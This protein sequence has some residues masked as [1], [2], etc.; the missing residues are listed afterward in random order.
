L[1]I[2]NAIGTGDARF[3]NIDLEGENG[4]IHFASDVFSDFLRLKSKNQ[5]VTFSD[6]NWY[7]GHVVLSDDVDGD[8]IFENYFG[9]VGNIGHLNQ[10]ANLVKFVSTGSHGQQRYLT[11]DIYSKKV[12]FDQARY[13]AE[14]PVRIKSSDMTFTN[15]IFDLNGGGVTLDGDNGDIVIAKS[16]TINY[17]VG[18][19]SGFEFCNVKTINGKDNASIVVNVFDDQNNMLGHSRILNLAG[20]KINNTEVLVKNSNWIYDPI[21]QAVVRR[22]QEKPLETKE[23]LFRSFDDNSL[24]D[25]SEFNTF[26]IFK[27]SIK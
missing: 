26:A 15:S 13:I 7:S 10:R 24:S 27:F 11:G 23:I 25:S 9:L 21:M 1:S 22:K 8:V 16:M 14:R 17:P 2:T 5:T 19:C 18:G 12:S 20:I 4:R 3:K 6:K